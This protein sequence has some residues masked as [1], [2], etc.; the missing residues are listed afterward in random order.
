[1]PQKMVFSLGMTESELEEV[2]VPPEAPPPRLSAYRKADRAKIRPFHSRDPRSHAATH[3]HHYPP[4]YTISVVRYFSLES[5]QR[6]HPLVAHS[7][8]KQKKAKMG[9]KG[10]YE[11]WGENVVRTTSQTL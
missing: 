10:H 2:G 4:L 1:M 7:S 6:K 8:E 5:R 11:A 9:Q 3:Q